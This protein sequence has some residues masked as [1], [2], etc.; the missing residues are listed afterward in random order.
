MSTATRWAL[1]GA[2]ACALLFAGLFWL[3][4][5]PLL[6]SGGAA[7]EA[8]RPP[9]ER[10]A[11]PTTTVPRVVDRA[12][13][14]TEAARSGERFEELTCEFFGRSRISPPLSGMRFW[15]RAQR[16]MK[17]EPGARFECRDRT[18]ES[19]GTIALSATFPSLG[20]FDGVGSGTGSITWSESTTTAAAPGAV[21]ST[22]VEIELDV[23]VVVVWTTIVEGPYAGYRGRLV[24]REWDLIRDG[25]SDIV[26]IEFERT[27]TVMSPR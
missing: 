12:N 27:T 7:A 13:L 1:V 20:L 21:S 11:L 17:L 2:L 9:S 15:A 5:G 18:S 8:E 19:S 24:L 23:P 10:G 16:A 4:V 26:G 22:V 14:D 25:S 6:S 3:V